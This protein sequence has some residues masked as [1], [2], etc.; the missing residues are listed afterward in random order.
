VDHHGDAPKNLP[1]LYELEAEIMEEV[2]RLGETSVR[3]VQEALNARSEKTRAYTTVMTVMQRLDAK[4]FLRRRREG[5]TD[6]YQAE[7]SRDAYG[8][9]RAAAEV[10]ELV[11]QYGEMALVNFART[12]A[13]LDPARRRQLARLARRD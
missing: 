1:G 8:S 3:D 6:F 12:M 13:S 7:I 2:W 4:G 11:E 9:M 10:D 5:R